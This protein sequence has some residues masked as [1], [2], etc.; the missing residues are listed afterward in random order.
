MKQRAQQPRDRLPPPDFFDLAGSDPELLNSQR[1]P[2]PQPAHTPLFRWL[3]RVL[4]AIEA[5]L[6]ARGAPALRGTIRFAWLGVM[7]IGLLLIFGPIINKPMDF[8]DVIAAADVH[9]VDWVARDTKIDYS[10]ERAADGTFVTAVSERFNADFINGPETAVTRTLV[11]E[12]EGHDVEFA[13]RGATIDGVDAEA[14]T[15]RRPTTTELRLTRPDGAQ[16][17]GTQEVVLTYELHHLIAVEPDA[18]TGQRADRF[19]W[20]LFAPTWPQATKGIEVSLTLTPELNDALVRP[21]KGS[22]GWLLLSSSAWLSVEGTTAE[23]VRYAFENDQALPPNADVWLT[24]TFEPGTFALPPKTALFWV[25]TYGPILPMLLLA[26]L[27][28]AALAARRVVWADSAGEPWFL[29]RSTPPAGCSPEQAARLRGKARHAE[30][31]QALAEKPKGSRKKPATKLSVPRGLWMYDLARAAARA[32]RLG[33]MPT[34]WSWRSKWSKDDTVVEEKLRWVPDGY[35]RQALRLAPIGLVLVQWGLLRQLSEQVILSVVWWPFAFVVISTA[36]AL[37][38]LLVTGRPRPLTPKGARLMQQLRGIDVYAETTRLLERGPLTDPVLPY[39]LLGVSPRRA[40]DAIAQQVVAE[41]G[42]RNPR[43]GWRTANFVSVPALA[44][45]A[46]ALAVFAGSILLVSTT[47]PPYDSDRSLISESGDLPGTVSTQ[48]EG[49]TA[50]AALSRDAEG[51]GL[52]RV[53]ER[54][55]VNFASNGSVPQLVREWPS[56][57]ADQ[58]LGLTVF[59]VRIDGAPVPYREIPQ[60]WSLAVVTQLAEVLQGPH[61]VEIVYEL[62]APAVDPVDGTHPGQQ[63]RWAAWLSNWEDEFWVNPLNP[64]DGREPLRPLSVQLTLSEDLAGEL[65]SGGWIDSD[66]D[67]PEPP[68]EV[69]YEVGNWFAPWVHDF[70]YAGET[71]EDGLQEGSIGSR[72]V[73]ADGSIVMTLDFSDTD[74]AAGTTVGKYDVGLSQDLG[75][76]LNFAP[77]TFAGVDP[78]GHEQYQRSYDLPNWLA[79]GLAA[80]VTLAALASAAFAFASRRPASS[81]QTLV[82]FGAIPL[83]AIAQ[84]I[85]FFW[86]YMSMDGDD[87]RMIPA[88]LLDAPMWVAVVAQWVMVSKRGS[89]RPGS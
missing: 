53:T 21:P 10:V 38:I 26:A 25:Q 88:L 80:F 60:E 89:S 11:T 36:L 28:L 84:T 15:V 35:V 24:A 87:V 54:T 65:V 20:P 47:S 74:A 23:G 85:L 67:R 34:V 31:V 29:P 52:L 50:E 32:G 58:D 61:E 9:E 48:I 82:A 76:L 40:G 19:D 70:T 62:A 41:T 83:A 66:Y 56:E 77:G 13:L 43:R 68:V 14:A 45:F 59:S 79:L 12:F 44:A 8:D 7:A 17:E 71:L 22:V 1:I 5:R 64:Y 46:A 75:V 72:T 86:T 6:R 18:A 73:Q 51:R 16:L 63:V 78:G 81:S 39:A 37:A 3:A 4:T 69:Q 42:E 30:L 2:D 55:T 49:F 33:N 27:L 57:R